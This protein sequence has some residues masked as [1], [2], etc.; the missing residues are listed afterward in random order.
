MKEPFLTKSEI[1]KLLENELLKC[2]VRELR[3][4]Y[5]ILLHVKRVLNGYM[6]IK[7]MKQEE[8]L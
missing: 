3:E 4:T 1:D 5:D 7:E 2:E 8:Y 6:E